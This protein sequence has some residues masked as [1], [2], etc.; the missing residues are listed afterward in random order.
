MSTFNKINS[1][2]INTVHTRGIL[3]LSV[4]L[5]RMV[6]QIEVTHH[7]IGPL[8]GYFPIPDIGDFENPIFDIDLKFS[9]FA[10]GKF[11]IRYWVSIFDIGLP[12]IRYSK[13]KK[14]DIGYSGI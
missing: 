6:L 11:D 5:G 8:K 13:Q 14:I 10:L 7:L 1:F 2:E 9:I 12:K 3:Q 4:W